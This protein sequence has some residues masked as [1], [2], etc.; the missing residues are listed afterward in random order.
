MV[1]EGSTDNYS[2]QFGPRLADLL[3]LPALTY[4]KQL[5]YVDGRM[6]ATATWKKARNC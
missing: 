5:E 1:G 2:G 6:K 4:V 3:D